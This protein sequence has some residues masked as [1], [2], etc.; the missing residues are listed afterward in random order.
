MTEQQKIWAWLKAERRWQDQE[1]RRQK[2]EGLSEHVLRLRRQ[3]IYF[4]PPR[5]NRASR[6]ALLRRLKA[7]K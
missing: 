4:P 7:L 3:G 5:I 6:R 2:H 1:K